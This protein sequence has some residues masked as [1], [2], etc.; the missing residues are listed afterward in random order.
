MV[1]IGA[2]VLDAPS[3]YGGQQGYG[4]YY[5][6]AFFADPDKFKVEVVHAR[7]LDK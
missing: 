7:G 2:E 1:L 3:Q 4:E 6:A 5:Y